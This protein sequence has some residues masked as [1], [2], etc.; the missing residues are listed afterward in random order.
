MANPL[1]QVQ[2]DSGQV[3][4]IASPDTNNTVTS[5]PISATIFSGVPGPKRCRGGPMI[6][7]EMPPSNGVQ[8]IEQCYNLP[9]A[10][11]CGNFVADKGDGCEARLFAEPG[12]K[13]YMNTAVFLPEDRAVGGQWRSLAVQCGKPPPDPA[14]LG[15]PPLQDMI[16]NAKKTPKSSRGVRRELYG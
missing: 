14:T 15:A 16:K 13:V 8:T 11:G 4:I 5:L 2:D 12:C 10:A 6:K 7:M 1:P 9:T 3:A